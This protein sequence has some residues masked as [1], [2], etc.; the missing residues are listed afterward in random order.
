MSEEI[1]ALSSLTHLVTNYLDRKT[2]S[3]LG[4]VSDCLQCQ[5]DTDKIP[6]TRSVPQAAVALRPV[7]LKVKHVS[8]HTQSRRELRHR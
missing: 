2:E 4:R 6:D 5:L 7:I 3:P 8:T 1:T